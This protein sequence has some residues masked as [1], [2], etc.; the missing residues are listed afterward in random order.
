MALRGSQQQLLCYNQTGARSRQ[1]KR[2]RMVAASHKARV[3]RFLDP[4]NWAL[5][6]PALML[7]ALR[8]VKCY[9]GHGSLL[10]SRK[11]RKVNKSSSR[12]SAL[13]VFGLLLFRLEAKSP[14]N[15]AQR[16]GTRLAESGTRTSP[17]TDAELHVR[18]RSVHSYGVPDQ[19]RGSVPSQIIIRQRIAV[20]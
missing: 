13:I 3:D 7:P 14:A 5:A 19:F 1:V 4:A 16:K 18:S 12:E 11:L 2:C 6:S 20:G 15:N 10:V 9:S 8:L 17:E